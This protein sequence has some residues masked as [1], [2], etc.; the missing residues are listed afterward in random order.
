[1]PVLVATNEKGNL[2]VESLH[3][4][5]SSNFIAFSKANALLFIPQGISF[6]AG[7]VAQILFLP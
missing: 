7:D 6:Q 5:G 3:F 4:T 2:I 1:L